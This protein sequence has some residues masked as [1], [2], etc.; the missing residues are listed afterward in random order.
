MK[1]AFDMVV[2]TVGL[3]LAAPLM[4]LVALALKR[5]GSV[6]YRQ[7]RQ[8]Q[9]NVPFT[10]LKFRTMRPDAEGDGRP[11]WAAVQDPRVT[12]LGRVLRR[13][14]ID[15][16][17]QLWNVLTGSMSIVGPR[18]ERPEYFETLSELMPLWS[19][20]TL[21]KPGIT[22]WAQIN[23]GYAADFAGAESKLSYDLW[24]LRH[25]SLLVDAAICARTFAR[26]TSGAR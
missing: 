1:R 9:G 14:R 12:K 15:E 21:L 11:V 20:R 26:M 2:A 19:F 13:T 5:S 10:I 18:P 7:T 24:Y 8:G 22:G 6:L 4:L 16:L 23:S 17:P 3:V 25:R